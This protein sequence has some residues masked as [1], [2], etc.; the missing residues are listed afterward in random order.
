M[1]QLSVFN[2]NTH[3]VKTLT[4]S[5]GEILFLAQ[6]VCKILDYKNTSQAIKDNCRAAGISARYIPELSNTY[7]LI[8]EGNLYR[9]LIKSTKPEA[10]HFESWI[11]D[12]VLPSIRKTGSYYVNPI[13]NIETSLNI[14]SFSDACEGFISLSKLFGY[15]G[16][17]AYLAADKA[18]KRLTG[19]SPLRLLG[20]EL[21]AETKDKVFNATD[22]AKISGLTTSPQRMNTLLQ[23]A[24]FQSSFTNSAGH[25]E[26]ILTE[27]GKPF[28]EVLDVG[29]QYSNGT[30]IKQIKWYSSVIKELKKEMS[31]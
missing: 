21:I 15:E 6:D 1:N 22:L 29:K 27:K 25:N 24:G 14:K 23:E 12:E 5:D 13:N 8:D 30:P 28:A 19:E 4:T 9:L 17:Q 20:I 10:K 16:N 18:V 3:D 11:C 31:H 2:F 7:I 26:W